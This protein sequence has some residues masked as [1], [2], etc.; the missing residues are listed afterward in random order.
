MSLKSPYNSHGYSPS[1]L[2]QHN[3]SVKFKPFLLN[4]FPLSCALKSNLVSLVIRHFC[5]TFM[6]HFMVPLTL[7]ILKIVSKRIK[8]KIACRFETILS[9]I[10]I[11]LLKKCAWTSFIL[12]TRCVLW[13]SI[14]IYP[15][16][17]LKSTIFYMGIC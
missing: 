14:L 17:N 8:E 7:I 3:S 5:G 6:V 10:F 11:G 9:L 16:E 4:N 12:H 15:K 1:L 13:E 2:K